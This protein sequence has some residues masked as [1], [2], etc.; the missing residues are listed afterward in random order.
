MCIMLSDDEQ[1]KEDLLELEWRAYD[2]SDEWYK[3]EELSNKYCLP[4]RERM[5]YINDKYNNY[6]WS[7]IPTNDIYP[8]KRIQRIL[9]HNIGKSFDK[10]YS[11]YCRRV[12]GYQQHLFLEEFTKKYLYY[13]KFS[14]TCTCKSIMQV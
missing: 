11:Y 14:F 12:P 8:W 10:A 1:W 7:Y 9:D 13:L 3:Q 5:K 6:Y 2:L 4:Y